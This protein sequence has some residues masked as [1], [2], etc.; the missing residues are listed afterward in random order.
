MSHKPIQKHHRGL[1]LFAC[2][3]LVSTLLLICLG[4]HVTSKEAGMAVPD[5]PTTYGENMFLYPIHKWVGG[6]F[7]EHSHRLVASAVG[8]FTIILTVW[9]FI[10]Y[11]GFLLRFLTSVA[12]FLVIIQG[13]LGGLRVVLIFPEIGIIH[14]ALAQLFFSL[15]AII[16]L[17]TSRLWL[18]LQDKVASSDFKATELKSILKL[19][20]P[21]TCFIFLQLLLGA[22]IRH[23]HAGLSIP[24][25]P[26]HYGQIIPPMGEHEVEKINEY[27]ELHTNL[28]PTSTLQIA[29][30]FAHRLFA[31]L[32]T[33]L[34]I[35]SYW[36]MFKHSKAGFKAFKGWF[37]VW[38]NLIILQV[39]LGVSV[40]L[41]EK[42]AEF[43]TL[44]VANGA[45]IL[46]LGV[47]LNV[48]IWQCM[49]LAAPYKKAA[50]NEVPLERAVPSGV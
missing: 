22:T 43:A 23:E 44:H 18:N 50:V 35:Y 7:W 16:S 9:T 32:I 8:M 3:T 48:L 39:A 45:S 31:Y 41:T 21:L 33:A 1:H 38:I 15:I 36:W 6:I 34:F 17:M 24:D 19:T 42:T 29:L 27:R 28:P 12:L 26:L 40:I 2:F 46:A 49:Q 13:I 5:W 25:F 37:N 47:V 4:G 11:K 14:G 10:K 20:I 30:H